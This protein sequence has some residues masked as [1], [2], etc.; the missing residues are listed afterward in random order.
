MRLDAINV[1]GNGIG[2]EG[3]LALVAALT[4]LEENPN[5]GRWGEPKP[6]ARANSKSST[7][8]QS[9]DGDYR[10]PGTPLEAAGKGLRV[11]D[12]SENRI[13]SGG[14]VKACIEVF[15]MHL[16]GIQELWLEKNNLGDAVG[17][18]VDD[19]T[20]PVHYACTPL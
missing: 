1:R 17:A 12:V 11:L 15:L 19:M 2:P 13:G 10:V 14:R 20:N 3:M 18:Q 4:G 9:T 6:R 16:P 5:N 7:T 8:T